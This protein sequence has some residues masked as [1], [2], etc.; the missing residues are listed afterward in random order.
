MVHYACCLSPHSSQ[1]KRSMDFQRTYTWCTIYILNI[2]G[3]C[4]FWLERGGQQCID[5]GITESDLSSDTGL[6]SIC[7]MD[8]NLPA[9]RSLAHPAAAFHAHCPNNSTS[10]RGMMPDAF[11]TAPRPHLQIYSWREM[12]LFIYSILYSILHP[13]LYKNI[14]IFTQL[15]D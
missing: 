11:L 13:Q 4:A 7:Q 9:P 1:A 2:A 12:H 10:A 6:H 5:N 3:R 15:Q 14:F 8:S